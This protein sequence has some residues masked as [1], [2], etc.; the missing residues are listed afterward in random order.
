[1]LSAKPRLENS[2]GQTTSCLQYV[3]C[4]AK[5]KRER[6]STFKG[7]EIY[8]PVAMYGIYLDPIF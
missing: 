4:K 7:L 2:T 8:Q 3:N 1:M 6:E 5:K